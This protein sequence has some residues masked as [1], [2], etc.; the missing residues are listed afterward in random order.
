MHKDDKLSNYIL[1]FK[2]V[3]LATNSFNFLINQII[4]FFNF[5]IISGKDADC[6]EPGEGEEPQG[7]GGPSQKG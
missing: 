4:S 5:Q 1:D 6:G 7:G 3:V 2:L